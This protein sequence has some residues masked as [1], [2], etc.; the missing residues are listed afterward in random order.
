MELTFFGTGNARGIPAYGCDC[1]VCVRARKDPTLVR[2]CPAQ[3]VK[4]G[5]DTLV[6]DA[7]RFD[8]HRLIEGDQVDSILLSHFHPDHVYGLFMISWGRNREVTVHAPPDRAGY[9]DLIED[10]GILRFSSVT[11]FEPFQIQSFQVTPFPLNH[12]I[13]TYGYAIEHDGSRLAYVMDT[14]GLPGETE[15]FLADWKPDVAII[16]SNQAPANP[17]ASHNTAEQA[18]QIHRDIGA[19]RSYL[20]HLSCSVCAWLESEAQL[21]DGVIPAQDGMEVDLAKLK[22]HLP[23]A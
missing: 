14:C 23:V 2:H 12:S 15:A 17:R 11:P 8:L 19:S 5:D 1:D 6:I 16:D 22:E 3:L 18:I 10:P 20:S 13:L 21:P 7:G 9:A 4:G